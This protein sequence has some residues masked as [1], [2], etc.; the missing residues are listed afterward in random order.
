[1][2]RLCQ[3]GQQL[4]TLW[5]EF[6]Y[7]VVGMWHVSLCCQEITRVVTGWDKLTISQEDITDAA[8]QD[9]G[10]RGKGRHRTRCF[11]METVEV[12]GVQNSGRVPI[13]SVEM[14]LK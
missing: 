14:L 13:Q 8:N 11:V 9:R 3:Q 4:K 10:G 7:K 1:M 5:P 6:I 2:G 12:E